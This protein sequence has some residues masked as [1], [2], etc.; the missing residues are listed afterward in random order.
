MISVYQTTGLFSKKHK[1]K[2]SCGVPVSLSNSESLAFRKLFNRISW[3]ILGLFSHKNGKKIKGIVHFFSTQ[4][5]WTLTRPRSVRVVNMMIS[6]NLWSQT[7][8]QK[9]AHVCG[10]GPWVAMYLFTMPTEGISIYKEKFYV[11]F[12]LITQVLLFF[13]SAF[14]SNRVEGRLRGRDD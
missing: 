14:H 13:N 7:T 8:C 2:K 12:A 5:T 3:S 10:R 11:K 6:D 4:G 9:C 1:K